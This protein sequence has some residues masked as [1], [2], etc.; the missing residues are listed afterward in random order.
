MKKNF[1]SKKSAF[2]LIELSIVLI[3]IGLL[4]AGI[5]G[6][7]SLIKSSELRSIMGEARG[8]A[9]SVNSFFTQYDQYPG[10]A[11]VNVGSSSIAEGKGDR[12]N[13]IEFVNDAG[14]KV[15]EGID[16]WFDLKDIGAIDLQLTPLTTTTMADPT[17]LTMSQSVPGSKIKGAGWAF[18]YNQN[19]L[20]NVVVLTGNTEDWAA[21]TFNS[22]VNP[23]ATPAAFNADGT[24]IASTEIIT[25]G[26]ALSIDSKIDDGVP[27]KGNVLA[28]N[29]L[30]AKLCSSS[31]T[32]VV[33]QGSTKVCALSFRVDVSS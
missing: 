13:K 23:V 26:D 25:A 3:I 31:A 7:A 19:A 20:Q 9:V 24:A 32:Y 10:D 30:S 2:S 18:D 1:S 12:D 11:N 28:V 14:T 33:A 8:Y 29:Q 15:A 27:N 4:I 5:T 17:A 21:A 16:A 22:L 6:G